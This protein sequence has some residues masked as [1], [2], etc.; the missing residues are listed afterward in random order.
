MTDIPVTNEARLGEGDLP[1]LYRSGRAKRA[2]A[3]RN[4]LISYAIGLAALAA[5]I[6]F[7]DWGKIQEFYFDPTSFKDQFPGIITTATKNTVIYTIGSFTLG[8]TI[9]LVMAI[10]K[11][12]SLRPYRWFAA[13]YI[14]IFRGLPALL[15]II[16]VGFGTPTVLGVQF[17]TIFGVPTG[18]IIALGLVA[19]AYLAETI[20]A[21]IQGVPK[22][23][24]EAARATLVKMRANLAGARKSFPREPKTR[25]QNP[26]R[27]G[28]APSLAIPQS[29]RFLEATLEDR[30]PTERLGL[31]APPWTGQMA[32]KFQAAVSFQGV[33]RAPG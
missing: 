23:Q 11:M 1:E 22:G 8:V 24:V 19:G 10:M 29:S 33:F 21:G 30:P 18:G 9:G 15:T 17:P 13:V 7:G 25:D 12:S 6:A 2:R 16:L 32:A 28:L 5:L 20:R 3:R 14:E 31:G 26:H 27:L 4:R